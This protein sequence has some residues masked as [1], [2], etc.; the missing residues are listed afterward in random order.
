MAVRDLGLISSKSLVRQG[1]YV[2][3][4][5]AILH[6]IGRRSKEWHY[7][8]RVCNAEIGRPG[9]RPKKA[10]KFFPSTRFFCPAARGKAMMLVKVSSRVG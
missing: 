1:L 8:G 5:R 4:L 7:L 10:R 9:N 6:R 3:K 2:R